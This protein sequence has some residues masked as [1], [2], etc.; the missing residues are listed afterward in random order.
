MALPVPG[1]VV[2]ALRRSTVRIAIDSYEYGGNGSGIALLNER[3]ITNAHVVRGSRIAVESWE[4]ESR[5]AQ[6]LQTDSRRDLALL[7][8]PGLEA[9]AGELGDS[10]RVRV[11]T[12]VL[13]VGNPLG[14][15]GA[16]SSGIVHHVGPAHSFSRLKWIYADLRLAPGN[17]GGPLA[18]FQG[19][20]IGMN[21]MIVGGIALAIPSRALQAFL[22]CSGKPPRNLGIVVRPV[23]ISQG[24]LGMVILE[25]TPG[26]A[27]E[28]ASLLPGDIL[29]GAGAVQ[30]EEL[31]DLK[32]AID[33]APGGLLRLAFYRAGTKSLRY[34]TVQVE[35]ARAKTAA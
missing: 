32:T 20:I 7:E 27:A 28:A 35:P 23:A 11:G 4:G 5:P 29:V 18:D 34:V 15:T 10:D 21:T 14:F 6:L 24:R 2:E 3:V 12:P 16:V 25:V 33:E 1:R 9:A 30:F 8:V 13:A 22:S 19:H 31:D 26:G 17:S